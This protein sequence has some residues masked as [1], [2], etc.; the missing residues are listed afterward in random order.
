[1]IH[2]LQLDR[3]IN[4]EDNNFN[5]IPAKVKKIMYLWQLLSTE[6]HSEGIR[7]HIVAVVQFGLQ[8]Q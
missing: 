7:L 6:P 4:E 3:H 1:M 8:D 5:Y 2:I